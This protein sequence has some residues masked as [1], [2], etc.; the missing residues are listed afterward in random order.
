MH[1]VGIQTRSQSKSAAAVAAVAEAVAAVSE[2]IE[3]NLKVI[4]YLFLLLFHFL[5]NWFYHQPFA[6]IFCHFAFP[7]LAVAW[8]D[9][10]YWDSSAGTVVLE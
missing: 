8:L 1:K 4:L 10:A 9:R 2:Q 6:G 7:V 3:D 5:L